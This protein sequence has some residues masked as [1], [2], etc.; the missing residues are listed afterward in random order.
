MS[1]TAREG[2]IGWEGRNG[3]GGGREEGGREEGG[4]RE[5]VDALSAWLAG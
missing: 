1:C 3:I 5:G 2:E 4:R